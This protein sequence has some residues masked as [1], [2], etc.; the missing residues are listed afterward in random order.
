[1][2]A[3]PAPDKGVLR[4]QPGDI[5]PLTS[6]GILIQPYAAADHTFREENPGVQI[7]QMIKKAASEA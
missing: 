4:E 6:S 3:E 2:H 1:M 7:F 5:V